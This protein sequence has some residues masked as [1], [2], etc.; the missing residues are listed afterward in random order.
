[1]GKRVYFNHVLQS[2]INLSMQIV[3]I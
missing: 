3:M 1:M 2:G